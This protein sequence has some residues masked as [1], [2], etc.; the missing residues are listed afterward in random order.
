MR[1]ILESSKKSFPPFSWQKHPPFFLTKKVAPPSQGLRRARKKSSRFKG[2]CHSDRASRGESAPE[3]SAIGRT[4]GGGLRGTLF[5]AQEGASFFACLWQSSWCSLVRRK[6]GAGNFLE[7]EEMHRNHA[8][9]LGSIFDL[10]EWSSAFFCPTAINYPL[11]RLSGKKLAP[12]EFTHSIALN[13][14]PEDLQITWCTGGK[15]PRR[16]RMANCALRFALNFLLLFPSREKG[17]CRKR[18][19]ARWWSRSISVAP[20]KRGA[21]CHAVSTLNYSFFRQ[22]RCRI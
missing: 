17:E 18:R 6:K 13:R 4:Y 15:S 10:S 9:A 12:P 2:Y 14:Q 22:V 20:L 11:Y 5:R 7:S 16:F 21:Q 3:H 19:K 8:N 1:N